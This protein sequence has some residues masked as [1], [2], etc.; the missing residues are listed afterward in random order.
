MGKHICWNITTKC[1]AACKFCDRVN[2]REEVSVQSNLSILEM[3]NRTNLVEKITWTGGEALLYDG[4]PQM[5][6]RAHSYGISNNL[7][8]NGK[9]LSPEIFSKIGQWLDYL[10]LSL[11]AIDKEV[12][13]QLGRS[14]RQF[15]QVSDI[16]KMVSKSVWNVKVKINTVATRV[17]LHEILRV[18]DFVNTSHIYRW[19]IFKFMPLRNAAYSKKLFDITDEEFSKLRSAIEVKQ[20]L[21]QKICFANQ[22]NMEEDYLL[23]LANGDFVIT[24]DSKDKVLFNPLMQSVSLNDFICAVS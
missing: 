5:L 21:G 6:E 9:A 18:E 17:N 15:D 10:T 19:K 22:S 8:T 1:N 2:D 16:V 23:I 7:I 11:D 14:S 12:N 13:V 4:L 24:K 3:L 20:Q